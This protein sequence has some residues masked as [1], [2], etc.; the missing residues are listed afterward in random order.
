VLHLFCGG[1]T[2]CST[3][4]LRPRVGRLLAPGEVRFRAC[5]DEPAD[6]AGN[7]VTAVRLLVF[8]NFDC[9]ITVPPSQEKIPFLG[10]RVTFDRCF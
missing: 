3:V 10:K 1:G 9:S 5:Y 8:V 6:Q 4:E 2:A 7:Q